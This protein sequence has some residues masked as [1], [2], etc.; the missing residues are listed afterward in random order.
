M[1]RFP[2]YQILINNLHI[3]TL[4]AVIVLGLS[5]VRLWGIPILSVIW[6]VGFIVM[7]GFVL[8]K[9]VCTTCVY[10]GERCPYSWGKWA[11][12]LFPKNSGNEEL[13][14]KLAFWFHVVFGTI[15][16]LILMI[17]IL[18]VRPTAKEGVYLAIFV[19]LTAIGFPLRRWNCIKCERRETCPGSAVR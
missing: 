3:F 2:M 16:P 1:K 5:P 14:F 7:V 6:A 10:Y 13:G 11:A 8:K 4:W 19:I 15:V 18:L 12:L 9:H 17:L